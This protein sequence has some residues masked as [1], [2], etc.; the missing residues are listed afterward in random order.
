MAR[1]IFAAIWLQFDDDLYSSF[2]HSE[3]VW[4]IAILFSAA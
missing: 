1:T 4:K 3:T 2:C